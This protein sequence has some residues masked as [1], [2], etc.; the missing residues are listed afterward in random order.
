MQQNIRTDGDKD[1]AWNFNQKVK[2]KIKV[3][4]NYL[5]IAM[6]GVC[7]VQGKILM[8]ESINSDARTLSTF[9]LNKT[10]FHRSRLPTSCI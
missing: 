4:D 10:L 8:R 5:R 2:K 3:S 9:R 1:D 7:R 6:E